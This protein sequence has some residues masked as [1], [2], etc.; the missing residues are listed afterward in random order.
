MTDLTPQD[1]AGLKA[2]LEA[3]AN[4][5]GTPVTLDGLLRDWQN[6]IA[7]IEHGYGLSLYDYTN[8]L[9]VRDR[10]DELMTTVSGQLRP[11]LEARLAPL[12][13]R[14]QK[15]TEVAPAPLMARPQ[16]WWR[17]IPRQ[18]GADFDADLEGL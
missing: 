14:F 12:D 11:K 2:A 15:A 10:L 18:R 6:F 16:S 9:S 13:A 5:I 7:E 1:Q 17:R 4:R 8:D 3:L